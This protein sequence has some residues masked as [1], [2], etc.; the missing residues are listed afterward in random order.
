MTTI[1][2]ILAAAFLIALTLF[3][4]AA[5]GGGLAAVASVGWPW[6]VAAIVLF[7]AG[8]AS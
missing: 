6:A 5:L 1:K 4:L 2:G 3:T 8:A 7:A